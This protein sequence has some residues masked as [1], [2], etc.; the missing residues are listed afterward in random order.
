LIAIVGPL[1]RFDQKAL[2]VIVN[3]DREKRRMSAHSAW[4]TSLEVELFG[5]NLT[6]NA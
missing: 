2:L 4:I 3:V 5:L 1:L 6:E